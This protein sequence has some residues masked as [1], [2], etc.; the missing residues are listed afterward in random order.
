VVVGQA[1]WLARRLPANAFYKNYHV[2]LIA[3]G[4]QYLGMSSSTALMRSVC[5]RGVG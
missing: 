2:Q 3:H 1:S 5:S 4:N